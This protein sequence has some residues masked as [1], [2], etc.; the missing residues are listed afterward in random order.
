MSA[1]GRYSNAV[2]YTPLAKFFSMQFGMG[3]CPSVVLLEGPHFPTVGDW[4][5]DEN[6]VI[7]LFQDGANDV[8]LVHRGA[9]GPVS[10]GASLANKEFIYHKVTRAQYGKYVH[11]DDQMD[12]FRMTVNGDSCL[13]PSQG[14][15]KLNLQMTTAGKNTRTVLRY[16]S[17]YLNA[18]ADTACIGAYQLNAFDGAVFVTSFARAEIEYSPFDIALR[19]T[20]V[21]VYA[22][23]TCSYITEEGKAHLVVYE[24]KRIFSPACMHQIAQDGT[25]IGGSAVSGKK[26]IA[27]VLSCLYWILVIYMVANMVSNKCTLRGGGADVPLHRI[28]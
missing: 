10:I 14:T 19:L 23:N 28:P 8:L 27:T 1:I 7:K 21:W 16:T 3:S 9:S 18:L 26:Y 20:P 12:N 15:L 4:P 11:S 17:N 22:I 24:G 5:R 6:H 13:L 2:L 25:Y